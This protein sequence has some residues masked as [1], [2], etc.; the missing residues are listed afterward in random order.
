MNLFQAVG[1]VLR[2]YA[3]FTGRARRSEYWYW[4]LTWVLVMVGAAFADDALGGSTAYW[5]TT[6][7]LFVPSLAVSVRR[8]HDIDRTGWLVL[9]PIL[10]ILALAL[11]IMACIDGTPGTN[12][13]GPSPKYGMPPGYGDP[14][15]SDQAT[16]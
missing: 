16:A 5:T 3:K 6:A 13:Y 7:V 8:L 1:S 12:K 15:V 2:N 4:V 11:L 10:P 9:L 14:V